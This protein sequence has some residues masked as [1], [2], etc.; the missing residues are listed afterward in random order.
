MSDFKKLHENS[1]PL[2]IANVWDVAS[3]KTAEKLGNQALGTSSAAI[4]SMLGYQDGEEMRFEE[5]EYIVQRICTAISI[6]LSVDLESGYSQ[7]PAVISN[8]IQ[9]LAALGVVGVNIEDS[10]VEKERDLLSATQFASCI[11]EVKKKLESRGIDMFINARTDSFLLGRSDAVEE[12][13]RRIAQYEKAGVDG[14]FIPCAYQEHDIKAI[15]DCTKLPVNVMCMP[16]LPSFAILK[17]WGVKRISM[18]NFLFDKM[19]TNH[20][21][22]LGQIIEDNSFQ[23][24]FE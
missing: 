3:A 22:I 8:H 24:V 19:Q 13:V 16:G 15:V 23:K 12:S 21:Q 14:I 5:L 1:Q 6:P 4:A 2:L 20:Y 18:G 9:R 17:D 10:Q 11:S 7:D